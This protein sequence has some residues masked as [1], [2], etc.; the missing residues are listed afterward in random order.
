MVC[1]LCSVAG[2]H[3]DEDSERRGNDTDSKESPAQYE[4]N[5]KL[6]Q[7]FNT[8]H[9]VASLRTVESKVVRP[10]MPRGRIPSAPRS[11][12]RGSCGRGGKGEWRRG[13]QRGPVRQ[14]RAVWRTGRDV[15]MSVYTPSFVQRQNECRTSTVGFAK[16]TRCLN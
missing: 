3:S 8:P 10:K 4:C 12:P 1:V 13:G 15:K 14:P 5:A 11:P 16:L 6:A 9:S 7:T 2:M